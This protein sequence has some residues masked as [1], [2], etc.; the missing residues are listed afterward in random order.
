MTASISAN[1]ETLRRYGSQSFAHSS[2]RARTSNPSISGGD[3]TV[4]KGLA[5]D[6]E[7][8]CAAGI[9][10]GN[11]TGIYRIVRVISK[12]ISPTENARFPLANSANFGR[13]GAPAP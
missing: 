11:T 2:V 6:H 9:R 8:T 12:I 10:R 13:N 5:T 7:L 1:V 3:I 4:T